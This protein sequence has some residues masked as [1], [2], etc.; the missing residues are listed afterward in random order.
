MKIVELD[1]CLTCVPLVLDSDIIQTALSSQK[2]NPDL[3]FEF[4]SYKSTLT[5]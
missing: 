2:W 1:A 4:K 3:M 5:S